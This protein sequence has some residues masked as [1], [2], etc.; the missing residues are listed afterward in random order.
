M[1]GYRGRSTVREGRCTGQLL[2]AS[3]PPGCFFLTIRREGCIRQLALRLPPGANVEILWDAQGH[4][5]WR[6]QLFHCF[7]NSQPRLSIL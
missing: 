2:F 1:L 3:L 6:R 5:C 7:Y 4:L